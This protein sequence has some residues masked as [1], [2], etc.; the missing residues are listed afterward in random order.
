MKNSWLVLFLGVFAL[1]SCKTNYKNAIYLTETDLF[2]FIK[3]NEAHFDSLNFV[4]K[5]QNSKRLFS[6]DLM[7]QTSQILESSSA[8][9]ICERFPFFCTGVRGKI[10]SDCG[11]AGGPCSP[12][13]GIEKLI[14]VFRR[15]DTFKSIQFQL[16]DLDTGKQISMVT[17]PRKIENSGFTYAIALKGSSQ[18]NYALIPIFDGTALNGL[19]FIQQKVRP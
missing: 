16:N 1:Q 15:I 17:T 18:G 11:P 4:L 3:L 13:P 19:P 2:Q 14:L 6:N 7:A 8:Y 5:N 9:N 10:N 12:V